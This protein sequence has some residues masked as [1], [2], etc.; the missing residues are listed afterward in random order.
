[1]DCKSSGTLL[2]LVPVPNKIKS[3]KLS[4]LSKSDSKFFFTFSS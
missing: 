3:D 2:K 4:L 1:M